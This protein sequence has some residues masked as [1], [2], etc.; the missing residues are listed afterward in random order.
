M[1]F[2]NTQRRLA[3]AIIGA[4]LACAV[5]WPCGSL[6]EAPDP[7]VKNVAPSAYQASVSHDA[8]KGITFKIGS[9]LKHVVIF[10]VGT[11]SMTAGGVLTVL[12]LASGY[13]IYVTNEYLWDRYSP[14][15]NLSARNNK[16]DTSASVW[17]NTKKYLTLKP[18]TMLATWSLIYAYTGSWTATL[19]M[20]TTA[21]V[22]GPLIFY[23]NDVG[24]DWYDWY[25]HPAKT[26]RPAPA[27]P[28]IT[29][30]LGDAL[31]WVRQ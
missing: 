11:G 3:G 14:N 6:A 27:A 20:G 5:L 22:V 16:F 13:V 28:E 1:T 31:A 4:A 8:A 23:A 18:A 17:R 12:T 26:A 15:P 30:R 9:V 25:S 24:W 10:S 2:Q 19:A 29:A 21:A 7:I